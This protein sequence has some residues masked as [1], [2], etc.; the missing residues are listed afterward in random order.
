MALILKMMIHSTS[1]IKVSGITY[2]CG[3]V[4]V[5]SSSLVP[6]FGEIEDLMIFS[7]NNMYIVARALST[8]AFIPH[9]HCYEVVHPENN[10]YFLINPTDL[11][12]PLP[13]SLY[14]LFTKLYIVLKYHIVENI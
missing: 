8:V 7:D 4:V 12:D 2:K 14:D 6:N 13:L 9:F 3:Q 10:E 5:V 11:S 1:W